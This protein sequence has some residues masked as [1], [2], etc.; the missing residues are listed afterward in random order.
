MTAPTVSAVITPSPMPINACTP[1]IAVSTAGI[2]ASPP[3][4]SAYSATKASDASTTE[5]P[6]AMPAAITTE[7]RFAGRKR[8][9]PRKTG[10]APDASHECHV[11]DVEPQRREPAVGEQQ[12]LHEQHERDADRPCPRADE[13]RREHA[14][15]R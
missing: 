13:D 3:P 14:P 1:P 6:A 15:S 4:P 10:I 8:L 5:T 11:E 7:G 12:R 2:D 9:M